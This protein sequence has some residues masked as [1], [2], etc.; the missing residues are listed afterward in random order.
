MLYLIISIYIYIYISIVIL[1]SMAHEDLHKYLLSPRILSQACETMRN[2]LRALEL[3]QEMKEDH[4][5][6]NRASDEAVPFQ[7][8][9]WRGSNRWRYV[10]VPYFW[11][12]FLAIFPETKA[13]KIGLI[14]G[15]DT[16]ILGSWNSHWHFRLFCSAMSNGFFHFQSKEKR[17]ATLW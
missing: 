10:N 16:S 14:Y 9:I 7:W 15:I 12:Y 13:W 6:P 4:L 17:R 1:V 2:W 5:V 3:L 11:P 8:E